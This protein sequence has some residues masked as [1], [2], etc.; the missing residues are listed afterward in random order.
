GRSL[1]IDTPLSIV[2]QDEL[3]PT[4]GMVMS[5]RDGLAVVQTVDAIGQ[6]IEGATI[7]PD[8]G[9][10]LATSAARLS[11]M[12]S[13]PDS[14]RLGPADR[15]GPL[16]RARGGVPESR[17]APSNPPTHWSGGYSMRSPEKPSPAV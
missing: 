14:Y 10:F 8:R 17:F 12:L 9:G 6:T 1:D 15:L 11:E 7:V 5:C 3:E 16:L 4:E 2:P 13:Q